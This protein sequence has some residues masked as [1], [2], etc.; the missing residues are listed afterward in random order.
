MAIAFGAAG[1]RLNQTTAATTWNV[2]YP[3]GISAGDCLV[4]FISSNGGAPSA[5][6]PTG[7]TEVFREASTVTNP[8]GGLY[9]KIA[10]G[11]E[12][13][14]LA[15][16]MTST[17]GNAQMLR[18]TGVDATTPQDVTRSIVENSGT[19]VANVVLPSITTVTNGAMLV[20]VGA[21]NSSS[22]TSTAPAGS[23]ERIDFI[24]DGGTAK[25]GTLADEIDAT[26]GATGTRTL[27]SSSGTGIANWGAMMALRPAGTAGAVTAVAATATA[28]APAPA[29]SNGSFPGNV[30]A[31]A[32]TGTAVAPAPAV[33]NGAARFRAAST[34]SV[35]DAAVGANL[36]LNR[37]TGTVDGDLL[38][39]LIIQDQDA[40]IKTGMPAPTGWTKIANSSS[41]VTA[42]G[43]VA[44]Y[45]HTAAS[46]D[47]SSWNWTNDSGGVPDITGTML[48]ITDT[49]GT[50][51]ASP[52]FQYSSATG[53]SYTAPSVTGVASGL[54]I[55][56]FFR[57]D[58][59]NSSGS[60]TLTAPLV[61]VVDNQ[62]A[63]HW[64]GLAVGVE[65]LTA[66][67]ATG[68]RSGTNTDTS[69]WTTASM[70]VNPVPA[71]TPGDVTAVAATGSAAAPAPGV[72]IGVPVT[73]V[74][75]TATAAAVAP[76]LQAGWSV[77]AV[78]ATATAAAP[79]PTLQYGY[80][81]V[82]VKASASS[83]GQPPAVGAGSTVTAVAATATAAAVAPTVTAGG[84]ANVSA[85]VA[86][87]SAA[88]PAPVVGGGSTLAAVPGAATV[89]AVGPA[90]AFGATVVALPATA[91][92]AARVPGVEGS[93]G[94]VTQAVVATAAVAAGV[95]D[96]H[97]FGTVSPAVIM[98]TATAPAPG[99]QG[100]VNITA[101]AA[102]A[103]A[104]ALPPAI[105]TLA[106]VPAVSALV[107]V[108]APVPVLSYGWTQTGA[109]A[110]ATA[111][112]RVPQNVQG[113]L[114]PT[115]QAVKATATAAAPAPSVVAFMAV[116][117]TPPP[118]TATIATYAPI[119]RG[120]ALVV[121]PSRNVAV[122]ARPVVLMGT[123]RDLSLSGSALAST[124][125]AASL[126][127]RIDAA[128]IVYSIQS[129][130]PLYGPM[131]TEPLYGRF[132]IED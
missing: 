1:T 64:T 49:D 85:V 93:Q 108:S 20:F 9:I 86:T 107:S 14:T 116:L 55:C 69:R 80:T 32:A 23:T 74:A 90:V 71:N 103:T 26:A 111:G 117:A 98:L 36:T 115:V 59:A 91:T 119:Q 77:T 33:S 78:G 95:P 66:A 75:G 102:A 57:S 94:T 113:D 5:T 68:T 101:P 125:T 87:V 28:A 46:G 70:V 81:V 10:T 128:P 67:G 27:T 30:S 8:R 73:A 18:Y 79:A 19:T 15:V 6:P 99:F 72:S 24:A 120:L 35:S 130:V 60:M 37:P 104:A 38:I 2:A 47:P 31:V 21:W 89:A 16:T 63:A 54:L 88:A 96:L 83:A 29:V 13:G 121:A 122:M 40:T 84:T 109:V 58:S 124:A 110:V 62:P 11:S 39:A 50:F 42:N 53:T 106:G 126:G 12:S 92:A 52:T 132:R 44:I 129:G 3:A 131:T 45:T 118:A 22:R 4:L 123:L 48:A 97:A 82:A 65:Q 41:G 51:A 43:Q 114:A 7:W 76:T 61:E 17:T 56:G 100:S 25:A 112:A 34:G 127:T 105:T